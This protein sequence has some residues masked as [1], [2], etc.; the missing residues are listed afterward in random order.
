MAAHYNRGATFPEPPVLPDDPL[1]D[2]LARTNAKVEDFAI[3]PDGAR[4]AYVSAESGGYD[5]WVIDM[6]GSNNRCIVH[7]YPEQCL[8]P[9]WSPDGEWISYG[10]RY[11]SPTGNLY[12]VRADGSEPPYNITYDNS[13][14]R[15]N[16]WTRWTPDGA[17]VVFTGAGPTGYSQVKALPTTIPT[18][19]IRPRLI[20]N[21]EWNNTNVQVSPDGQWVAFQS[22]RSGY[23]DNKRMDVFIAPMTGGPGRNLT[24]NTKEHH[25]SHPRWSPD[26]T[27]IAFVSDRTGWRNIG[28]I[29]VA[30]GETTMLTTS[31][32]DE[33]NPYWS[34]DGKWIAYTANK[35]WNFHIMLVASDGSGEPIQLTE[36]DG[37]NG[38]YEGSQVRGSLA[39]TPDGVEIVYT[40]MDYQTCSDLWAIPVGGGTPRQ[41]TDH[42]PKD[43]DRSAFVEPELIRWA[44]KDGLEVPGWLYRPE[45]AT[46]ATPL[47]IFARANTHGFHVNGFYPFI[48]YWCS[49]GYTVVAPEVRGSGGLGKTYETMNFGEWGGGDIDDIASGVEHL[50]GKGLIDPD[51]VAMHG[52]STGGYFTNQTVSRY[53]DLLKAGVNFYGPPD[54]VHMERY[55]SAAGR[56]TLGDV[57]GGDYGGPDIALD[58]WMERSPVYNLDNIVTPLLFLWGDRD[59]VRISMAQDY[60]RQAKAKGKYVEFIQYNC[61]HH[62]WYDWRP[63]TV[64]DALRRAAAH[65]TKF[66]GD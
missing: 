6:D 46:G 10:A 20:T 52:G 16:E 30:T 45:G 13:P 21:D 51:R 5:L 56:S 19:K 28:V 65:F 37:V 2:A 58:H 18:G 38:G 33:N 39:W 29:D 40:H 61:E 31:E 9:S 3:S 1:I 34:P 15:Y 43:L 23:A 63:E 11:S 54:L 25:D 60:F 64:A 47:V 26:S 8:L 59:G 49:K 36:G 32:C 66:L 57:V 12:I 35:G 62:G 50:A 53:P 24:P 42:M 4:I 22:D 48:Q 27:R 41:I 55:G 44:S 7:M 14:G 17:E